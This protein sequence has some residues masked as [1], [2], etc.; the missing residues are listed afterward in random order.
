MEFF[1]TFLNILQT[2]LDDTSQY[3]LINTLYTG[4]KLLINFKI[5]KYITFHFIG[6]HI[7]C[8]TCDIVTNHESNFRTL[9]LPVKR[10]NY[11]VNY[12]SVVCFYF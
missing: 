8:L 12:T 3:D 7:K 1:E 6:D 4:N 9:A 11:D 2:L 10:Y 5:R